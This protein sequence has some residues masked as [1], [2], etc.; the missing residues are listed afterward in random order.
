MLAMSE[1]ATAECD[2]HLVP[3]ERTV[4]C[5]YCLRFLA[6]APKADSLPLAV[7]IEELEQWLTAERSVPAELLYERIEELAGRRISVH[8]LDD[9]DLLLRRVQRPRRRAAF[10]SEGRDDG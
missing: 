5:G 3:F 7:R 9:P 10:A 6:A 8:E 2:I 4:G 1:S